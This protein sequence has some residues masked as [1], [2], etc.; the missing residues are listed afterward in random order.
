MAQV[1]D[2]KEF[3]VQGPL[4]RIGQNIQQTLS[5]DLPNMALK[6][7]DTYMGL[8]EE[9]RKQGK[10]DE[11]MK[12][13]AEKRAD[14]ETIKRAAAASLDRVA[15]MAGIS[16]KDLITAKEFVQNSTS[17]DVIA[18]AVVNFD[19]Y[20]A[21]Q[22]RM[23]EKGIPTTKKDVGAL[24]LKPHDLLVKDFESEYSGA[25]SSDMKGK[26][27]TALN[28]FM[29]GT[30]ITRAQ[31]S[32]TD[33]NKFMGWLGEKHGDPE[34]KA[35]WDWVTGE[36][37]KLFMSNTFQDPKA[38]QA[39]MDML[40]NER[41][42][43][44]HD[45]AQVAS[46]RI[47]LQKTETNKQMTL[48]AERKAI[49][50]GALVQAGKDLFSNL[51]EAGKAAVAAQAL[52]YDI[53]IPLSHEASVDPD[54]ALRMANA[55]IKVLKTGDPKWMDAYTASILEKTNNDLYKELQIKLEEKKVDLSNI[56][57]G[58]A[59][60]LSAGNASSE[61]VSKTERLDAAQRTPAPAPDT[62]VAAP[63]PRAGQKP[64]VTPI[65]VPDTFNQY[66]KVDRARDKSSPDPVSMKNLTAPVSA[67]ESEALD[68]YMDSLSDKTK[69]TYD[70]EMFGATGSPKDPNLKGLKVLLDSGKITEEQYAVA[71]K[72]IIV[73]KDQLKNRESSS[74]A[75]PPVKRS[76][77]NPRGN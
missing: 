2:I 30:R 1:P 26:T 43:R 42:A 63:M 13:I 64:V 70:Q 24:L 18:T 75:P 9:G 31:L 14:L 61:S 3:D 19:S 20:A 45:A 36:D 6:G 4:T 73:W 59:I 67:S 27:T 68:A 77:P 48:A 22:K 52:P 72:R 28:T 29:E 23:V 8:Q 32:D 5:Q 47:G 74:A 25:Y 69:D 44:G 16:G 71:Q 66:G 51:D 12:A 15:V 34:Y 33:T 21:Q 53:A 39:K 7:V 17:T 56:P 60:D 46:A 37:G 62:V 40:S 41:I 50:D 10:Y 38:K 65:S 49:I 35:V 58:Q 11:D 57:W 76:R 54:A 55:V